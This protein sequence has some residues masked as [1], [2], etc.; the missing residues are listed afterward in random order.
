MCVVSILC[1]FLCLRVLLFAFLTVRMC[2][3]FC[4]SYILAGQYEEHHD[5]TC[6]LGKNP[7]GYENESL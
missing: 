6:K 5:D 1:C 4:I 3:A 2:S 7:Q